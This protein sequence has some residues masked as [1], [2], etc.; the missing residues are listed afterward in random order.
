M[1]R[2]L[3]FLAYTRINWHSCGTLC[4]LFAKPSSFVNNKEQ[5][6]PTEAW[7]YHFINSWNSCLMYG[8]F[9]NVYNILEQWPSGY[10]A[11]FPI[12]GS[13]VKNHWVAPSSTQS[14]ILPKATK[15]VQGIPGNLVVK[16]KL[17]PPSGSSLEAVEPY[18]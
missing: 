14:F 17:P 15:W 12:K 16:S 18:P 4:T 13:Y 10:G 5:A 6:C 1:R 8:W 2:F 3:H 7:K 9:C 11:G